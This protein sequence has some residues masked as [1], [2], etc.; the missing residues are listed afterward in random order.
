MMGRAERFECPRALKKDI[1][2]LGVEDG[3]ERASEELARPRDA[4]MQQAFFGDVFS[5][6][7]LRYRYRDFDELGV[8][9]AGRRK[10][11]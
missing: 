1:I 2:W 8:V 9:C 4:I 10:N 3:F 5:G 6:K 11:G 7:N